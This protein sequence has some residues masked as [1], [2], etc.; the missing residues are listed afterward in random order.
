MRSL[1][2][3]VLPLMLSLLVADACA[4]RG[5]GRRR[6]E[7]GPAVEL[8][9]FELRE[10][11]FPSENLASGRGRCDLYLPKG[12]DA[13]ER[14]DRRYPLVIWLHGFG[15]SSE[16]HRRGGAA[17]LDR[18]RGEGTIPELVVA[19][20]RGSGGRRE[21]TVYV[22]GEAGGRVED[23]IVQDLIAHLQANHPVSD[24]REHRAIMGISIG[25]FGA[26]KIAMKHPDKFAAVG[27]HSSAIFPDDPEELPRNYEGQVNRALRSGLAEVFGDPID[28]DKWAAEMPMGLVRR[29]GEQKFAGLRIYFDAGTDDRYGFAEPNRQLS[30]LLKEKG[31]E[32]TFRLV[33]GGGHAWS[34]DSMEANLAASLTFVGGAV[35]GGAADQEEKGRDRPEPA[36]PRRNGG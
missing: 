14:G 20:W 21:R 3:T 34:S 35:G 33:E 27:A 26:L 4:Q 6:G 31:I 15:G 18:L 10:V 8:K 9:H 7:R 19:V 30:E 32:H 12:S 28:K 25:G 11:E 5:E 2:V 36:G 17:T 13:E 22:N 23:A 29:A 1:P 24:R 16:F